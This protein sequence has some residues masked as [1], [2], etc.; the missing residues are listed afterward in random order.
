MMSK[1]INFDF[2]SVEIFDSFAIGEYKEGIDLKTEQ[3]DKLIRVCEKY[4]KDKPFGY[5]CNRTT[6]FSVDPAVYMKANN[7]ENLKAI[8]VVVKNPAQVLSA[9]IEKIFFGRSFQYFD[10]LSTAINWIKGIVSTSGEIISTS[11]NKNGFKR[12]PDLD[13]S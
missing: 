9:S 8:A 3:N 6:S 7:I 4:Y 11:E 10:S 2:G 12:Y 1:K 5:I 13:F